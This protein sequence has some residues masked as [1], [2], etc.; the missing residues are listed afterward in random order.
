MNLRILIAALVLWLPGTAEAQ[1]QVDV[2]VVDPGQMVQGT[3]L[4]RARGNSGQSMELVFHDDGREPD[5]AANDHV[6]VARMNMTDTS[7]QLTLTAGGKQWTGNTVVPDSEARVAIRLRLGPEGGLVMDHGGPTGSAE[8]GAGN[9]FKAF[10]GP[11]IAGGPPEPPGPGGGGGMGSSAAWP[12]AFL[13]LGLGFGLGVGI[14]WVGRNRAHTLVLRGAEASPHHS[15]RRVPADGLGA[16]LSGPLADA[17]IVWLG[18]PPV[19]DAHA[20]VCE[21]HRVTPAELVA[22]VEQAGVG[23]AMPMALVVMDVARLEVSGRADPAVTLAKGVGG[24]FA[25][26]VVDGPTDWDGPDQDAVRT[27]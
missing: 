6:Y 9:S 23:S 25:L 24:R 19:E 10:L 1:R 14:R 20:L 12:W 3:L 2:F 17:R 5:E 13:L 11:L 15:P 22:A 16:L 21:Q 27:G 7:V 4:G 26:W 18:E 8:R